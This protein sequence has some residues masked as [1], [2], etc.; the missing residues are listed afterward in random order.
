MKD[1]GMKE[2]AMRKI[3]SWTSC[4]FLLLLTAAGA[5]AQRELGARP[6]DSGGVLMPEQAAY[7]VASYDLSLK[8]NPADQSINGTLTVQARIVHPTDWFV[9][10]L[11]EPL[12]VETV[13]LAGNNARS[14]GQLQFKRSGGKI[15]IALPLTKQP[16]EIVK[17]SVAYGGKPRVAPRPPWVGGFIW[18]KTAAGQPW[19]ATAC[20]MDGADIWWPC[21]DHP[22]DEPDSMALHITVPEPLVVASNGRLQSVRK[23]GDGTQTFNWLI[24]VPFNN[25]SVALNIAPYRTIEGEFRSMTGESV[26]ITF[27]VLP[28]DYEKGQKLFP[29][30]AEHLSFFEKYL[31]PYPFR[32]EKVGVAQTPHLGMEHST[33]TAYGANFQNN[34]YGFDSLLFHELGHDW[35]ANLVTASDWRDF[36]LHEGF[37][38]FMDALYA[39]EMKGQ[40]GY[41][42]YIAGLHRGIRNRQPVAPVEARTAMQIY[43]S[44]PDYLSS[45]GDI[46]NKGALILHTLRYLIGDEAFFKALRRMA[47]PDPQ[48]ESVKDG[49]QFRFATTDDFRHL[50]EQASGMKLDWF[51]D[52]YLR[53]PAL[54]RLVTEAK[55]T[56]LTLRWEAPAGLK[57]PMPVE[58]QTG[59]QTR[60]IEVNQE[61]VTLPIE[62]GQTPVVDPKNRILKQ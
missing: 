26:P 43:M 7:D 33:V 10:D 36:W 17:I 44:A 50:A 55:G 39:G 23:N 22:S 53:Q 4:I 54:P 24:S 61:G 37:Q 25:Y 16:G 41:E 49:R 18:S 59:G 11:D 51:F 42:R 30:I 27:W 14:A 8:V 58:V 20:Q 1:I 32:A 56:A 3:L 40:E 34:A 2:K 31:G 21:K 48:M 46:Y 15:W 19:I 9:L 47:Y 29:Q 38:S 62:A 12:K 45:D 6:T 52:V 60:R 5:N 28:E 13:S 35:W 57:F